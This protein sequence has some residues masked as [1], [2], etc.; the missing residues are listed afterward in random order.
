LADCG[1]DAHPHV[2]ACN[3]NPSPGSYFASQDQIKVAHRAVIK[4]A[5]AEYFKSVPDNSRQDLLQALS[6]DLADLEIDFKPE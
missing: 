3:L 6:R 5:L 1:K 4:K 2:K